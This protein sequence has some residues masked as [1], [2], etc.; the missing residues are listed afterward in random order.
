M[1][2]S[3]PDDELVAGARGGSA[4]AF[5]GLV[6]RHAGAV[7]RLALRM[8]A[9]RADADEVVQ[10]TFLRVHQKLD[11]YRGDAPFSAWLR[12]VATNAILM[13]LRARRREPTG[14]LAVE[15]PAFD[16]T[17]T[18]ARLDVHCGTALRAEE[19]VERRELARAALEALGAL[20]DAYRVPFVLRDL[21]GLEPAEIAATLGIAPELVRQRVHRARLAIKKHLENLVGSERA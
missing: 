21:E 12:V 2:D 4:A 10:E 19:L 8:T 7:Y 13:A 1:D 18:L 3:V 11:S 15:L 20:P 16:E 5:A 9:S 14:A 17:G 6:S